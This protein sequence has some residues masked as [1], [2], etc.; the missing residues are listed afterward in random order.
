MLLY[1]VLRHLIKSWMRIKLIGV[2]KVFVGLISVISGF[3]RLFLLL[4]QNTEKI[5]G[6][7]FGFFLIESGG[8]FIIY[9]GWTEFQN[10]L[11]F[12]PW[13]IWS[14]LGM[15]LFIFF[16]YIILMVIFGDVSGVKIMILGLL[17]LFCV[18]DG[19]RLKQKY[20]AHNQ[21]K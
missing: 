14:G 13:L 1:I 15:A 8:L 6:Y 11:K 2:I 19:Y 3:V 21:K 18:R 12:K 7:L 4:P 5:A 20:E 16:T 10:Y 9:S 17:L